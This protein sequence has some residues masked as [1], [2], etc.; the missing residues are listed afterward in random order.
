[1]CIGG[2]F[3][4]IND[5]K[6]TRKN[7]R[8]PPNLRA[9]FH[10]QKFASI[11]ALFPLLKFRSIRAFVAI[12]TG[13]IHYLFIEKLAAISAVFSILSKRCFSRITGPLF[14]S[15][16]QYEGSAFSP[17]DYLPPRQWN[18]KYADHYPPA[19]APR[20]FRNSGAACPVLFP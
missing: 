6:P 1:M 5:K 2:I 3:S 12:P 19:Q 8:N 16:L 15:P 18:A 9:I 7:L 14:Q 11:P 10:K 4:G 17:P 20:V 13:E